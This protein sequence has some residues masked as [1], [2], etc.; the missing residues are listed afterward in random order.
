MIELLSVLLALLALAVAVW[1]VAQTRRLQGTAPRRPAHSGSTRRD[2]GHAESSAPQTAAAR[3]R[4]AD[5][6]T[7]WVSSELHDAGSSAPVIE[8]QNRSGAPIYDLVVVSTGLF[9]P[10][11]RRTSGRDSRLRLHIFPPGHLVYGLHPER[12]WDTERR[13][14]ECQ[15][16]RPMTTSTDQ[17]VTAFEFT[18]ASGT[19]WRRD[20]N[21]VLEE[22]APGP[23]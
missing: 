8:V 21:G 4:Q 12:I 18:D 14:D 11:P 6:V 1:A 16:L 15:R 5:D 7:A 2:A 10:G 19:R 13:P 3:R 20:E 17:K 9:S 22:V 23:Q